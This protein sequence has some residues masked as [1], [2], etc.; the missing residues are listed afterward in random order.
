MQ[1][2]TDI[3]GMR[4]AASRKLGYTAGNTGSRNWLNRARIYAKGRMKR[5]KAPH[6]AR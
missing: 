3:E 1:N 2:A 5:V 4:R 6:K